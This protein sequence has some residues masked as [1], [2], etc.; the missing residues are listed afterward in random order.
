M[1]GKITWKLLG[2]IYEGQFGVTTQEA[3]DVLYKHVFTDTTWKGTHKNPIGRMWK[4]Q[5]N[6]YAFFLLLEKLKE[7]KKSVGKSASRK[8]FYKSGEFV[9]F[10]KTAGLVYKK[11]SGGFKKFQNDFGLWT[12]QV[13]IF[14]KN[15]KGRAKRKYNEIEKS[16]KKKVAKADKILKAENI[17]LDKAMKNRKQSIES[18]EYEEVKDSYGN[19]NLR[20]L[21]K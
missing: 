4:D 10:I 13:P 15:Y 16:L 18:G 5:D 9:Y 14:K 21:K 20:R 12:Q 3:A 2:E 8:L 17:S 1:A 11:N 19:I 6:I 7:L